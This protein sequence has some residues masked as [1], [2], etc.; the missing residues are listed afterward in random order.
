M[1]YLLVKK[2]GSKIP[3]TAMSYRMVPPI[4]QFYNVIIKGLRKVDDIVLSVPIDDVTTIQLVDEPVD[5]AHKEE[6]PNT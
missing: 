4:F 3:I 2:D 6:S 1:N 5:D